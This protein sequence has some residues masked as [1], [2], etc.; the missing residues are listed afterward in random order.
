MDSSFLMIGVAAGV[1][2]G[3]V[4]FI[5]TYIEFMHDY[6]SRSMPI[7]FAFEGAGWAFGVFFA[8]S[9]LAGCIWT[10]AYGSQ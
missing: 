1:V 9:V 8:L 10:W 4:A 7:R 3:V 5:I 2:A 6:A